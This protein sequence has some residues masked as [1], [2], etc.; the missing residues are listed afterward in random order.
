MS[1]I[2]RARKHLT[3][4]LHLAL[5]IGTV[6]FRRIYKTPVMMCKVIYCACTEVS[7]MGKSIM[8]A[9]IARPR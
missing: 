7:S 3:T 8:S 9:D 1:L 6:F 2:P 5:K 4:I